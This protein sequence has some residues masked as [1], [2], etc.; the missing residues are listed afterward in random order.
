MNE[1]AT[2]YQNGSIKDMRINAIKPMNTLNSARNIPHDRKPAFA[3]QITRN[4]N[5]SA[6]TMSV[7]IGIAFGAFGASF[8]R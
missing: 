6:F 3:A 1:Q 4:G 8:F 5:G 7:V 2:Y